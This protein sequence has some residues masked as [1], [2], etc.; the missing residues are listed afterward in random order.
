MKGKTRG[1]GRPTMN[2]KSKYTRDTSKIK[3]QPEYD[4]LIPFASFLK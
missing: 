2:R 3:P 1:E 4:V